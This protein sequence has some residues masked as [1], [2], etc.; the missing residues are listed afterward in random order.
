MKDYK[1][2]TE[3]TGTPVQVTKKINRFFSSAKNVAS[4]SS[5]GK[6]RH[7]ALLVKGG[8]IINACCNK[9]SYS[10]FG[11][12]FR[13]PHRGHATVH[14]ELGCVLGIPRNV[15]SGADIYVCRINRNGQFRNSKPCA[16]CHS[17]LKH[18]GIKRVYYTT[19][20]NTIEMYK[21]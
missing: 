10:S 8:S 14:A 4:N 6:I 9:D 20:H 16:M 13:S 2:R 18:V 1:P 17:V 5:Y 19:S 7:G 11:K 3:K 21:L 12:R 15:T